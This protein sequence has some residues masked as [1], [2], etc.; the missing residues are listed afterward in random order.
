MK[1]ADLD[2][3]D[4]DKRMSAPKDRVPMIKKIFKLVLNREP[5]SRELSFYKYGIQK[6]EEIIEKLLKDDEHRKALKK[7]KEVPELEDRVKEAEHKVIKLQQQ[8]KDNGEELK[9]IRNLLDEKNKEI[10]ILRREKNDPYNFTHSDALKYIK[11]LTENKRTEVNTAP[12]QSAEDEHFTSLNSSEQEKKRSFLD[13]I[14]DL[15]KAR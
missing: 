3:S 9:Q 7:S 14:H 10:A 1:I 8:I 12:Q 13:R 4:E 6:E 2:F 5:S 15:V 11:K